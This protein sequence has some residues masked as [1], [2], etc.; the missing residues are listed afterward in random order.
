MSEVFN[1]W[2][3]VYGVV[4]VRL[5]KI[6]FGDDGR[7]RWAQCKPEDAEGWVVATNL[8]L[9]LD[10]SFGETFHKIHATPDE[11]YAELAAIRLGAK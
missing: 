9:M 10:S 3:T 1:L 6:R 5:S 7:P 4:P 2:R 11:A 8:R